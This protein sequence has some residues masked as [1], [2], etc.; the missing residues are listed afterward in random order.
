MAS[1]ADPRAARRAGTAGLPSGCHRAAR[2]RGRAGR[3]NCAVRMAQGSRCC[4]SIGQLSGSR[5]GRGVIVPGGVSAVPLV[6]PGRR[7]RCGRRAGAAAHRGHQAADGYRVVPGPAAPHRPAASR[8]GPASTV[9][10]GRSAGPRASLTT[11]G[12]PGP[13]PPMDLL[14]VAVINRQSGDALARLEVRVDEIA[15]TF[16]LLRQVADELAEA[17]SAPLRAICGPA[18]GAGSGLGGGAAWRGALRG[19]IWRTAG[20]RGAGPGRRH[21]TTW[22]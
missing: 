11:R 5:F 9:P 2:G 14:G 16:H 3:G 6:E 10:S 1:S 7:P 17:E 13:T 21:S 18:D 4:G 20:S 22:Y 15:N 8:T 19:A 12:R